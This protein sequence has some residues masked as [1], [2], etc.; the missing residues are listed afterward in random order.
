MI[1]DLGTENKLKE[2]GFDEVFNLLD[3]LKENDQSIL[4]SSFFYRIQ[5]GDQLNRE[6]AE[7]IKQYKLGQFDPKINNSTHQTKHG[8]ANKR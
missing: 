1:K 4:E 8:L 2:L 3:D 6:A 7:L 5:S